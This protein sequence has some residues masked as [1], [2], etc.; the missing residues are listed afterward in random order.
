MLDKT[1]PVSRTDAEWRR[2]LSPEQFYVMRAHGT[3]AP[4]SCALARREAAGPVYLCRM[5]PTA[6]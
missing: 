2:I 1:Y 5:R 3:E 6:V 4:G